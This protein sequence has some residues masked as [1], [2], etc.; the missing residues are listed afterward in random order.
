MIHHICIQTNTYERSF[1]FYTKVLGFKL[2]KET[3]NFHGRA[4]N[5]WLSLGDFM[6]ELQTGKNNNNLGKWSKENEGI[7]HMCLM[8]ENVH[9]TYEALKRIGYSNFKIKN[10][11]V[12]YQVDK[13]Y[14]FKVKAPEG[15]EIEIRDSNIGV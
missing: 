2:E 8:V 9:E 13:G 14:L 7:V 11:K 15:T 6:I 3:K 1:E 5:T 10:G 4:F 12:I